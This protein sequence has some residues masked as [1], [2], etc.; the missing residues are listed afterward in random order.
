MIDLYWR[1]K[2][3]TAVVFSYDLL[4][5]RSQKGNKKK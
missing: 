3:K 2:I 5:T 4:P 1:V